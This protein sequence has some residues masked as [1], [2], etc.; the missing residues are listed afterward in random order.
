[1]NFTSLGKVL[2]LYQQD[3]KKLPIRQFLQK[4]IIGGILSLSHQIVFLRFVVLFII[5]TLSLFIIKRDLIKSHNCFK[6]QGLRN[7]LNNIKCVQLPARLNFILII[8]TQ[9][10]V[11]VY[12][13]Q[14]KF[15]FPLQN[16]IKLFSWYKM[17]FQLFQLNDS[18]ILN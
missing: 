14:C 3:F 15:L 9:I 13:S 17:I 2:F 7:A 1:M 16:H 5:V 6:R 8:H 4:I 18:G 11:Y 12:I 10:M